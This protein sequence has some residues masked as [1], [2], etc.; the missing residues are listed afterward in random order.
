[1]PYEPSPALAAFLLV[2]AVSSNVSAATDADPAVERHI[3]HLIDDIP[4]GLII[5]GEPAS[6]TTLSARMAT[7]HVPGVS[8]AVIHNGKLEWARGFGVKKVGGGPVTPDTLFQAASISKPITALAVLRL[9]DAGELNL[10]TDVNE[11]LK[12][13]KIPDNEFTAKSRITLRELLSHTAGITVPGFGG[14]VS[15][16]PLPTLLQTLNGEFPA[17]NPPIRVDTLPHTMWRYAGGG[18]VILRQ[19]LEDV[20][21]LPFAELLR[22]TVLSPMGMTHSTFQQPLSD[23]ALASAAVPHDRE[24]GVVSTGPRVYPELAP[25]GLWST[26]S[27]LA[28]YVIAVQGSLAGRK[29]SLLSPSAARAMLTAQLNPYGLGAIVGDDKKHPWFTH[30]GGNYGYPCLFVAY[31]KGEG[32]AIMADGANGFELDIDILR[33]I[34]QEYNWP[35]FKPIK[36]HVAEVDGEMLARYVGVYQF[37]PDSYAAILKDGKGLTFQ[38]TNEAK[39]PIFPLSSSE[40]VLQDTSIN[41]L[42]NRDDEA[43]IS[44]KTDENGQTSELT[45]VGQG[46]TGVSAKRL[47]D[48]QAGPMLAELQSINRR[49]KNQTPTTDGERVL[50]RLIIDI[51]AGHLDDG[52]VTPD[53]DAELKSLR[54]LNQQV[55]SALGPVVSMSFMRATATGIDTYHIEFKNGHGEMDIRLRNDGKL[56]SVRYY[57]D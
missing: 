42:F 32:A 2:A 10:D 3:G 52:M 6:Y 36:H 23:P 18:Y 26:P 14:Y 15:G 49:F 4:P 22:D 35:D 27:D 1:M 30:N 41:Y 29:G 56:R 45:L 54:A 43:R 12:S 31:N 17:N 37:S 8:V 19:V 39:Q 51:S 21:G 33:S 11:Y 20:T 48:P 5:D 46:R 9:V 44:F 25:D 24:G 57:A 7:L 28:R 50:R 55:F 47:A 53:L 38:S 13:W 16:E 40:F 34:A